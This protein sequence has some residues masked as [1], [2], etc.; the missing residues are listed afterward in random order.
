MLPPG[1]CS[2]LALWSK[3]ADGSAINPGMGARKGL[4]MKI[5]GLV[6]IVL[7]SSAEW[8]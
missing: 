4:C 8:E 1:G 7:Y 5:F 3:G 6:D 2:S